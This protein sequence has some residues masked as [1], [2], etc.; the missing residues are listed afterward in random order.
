MNKKIKKMVSLF[1]SMAM[2]VTMIT[3][4]DMTVKASYDATK[5]LNVYFKY[6]G[7]D[8]AWTTVALN[9][10]SDTTVTTLDGAEPENLSVLAWGATAAFPEMSKNDKGWYEAKV[11]GE[12]LDGIDFVYPINGD[13]QADSQAKE[14]KDAA[15][16]L[17]LP[18]DA[19]SIY[20]VYDGTKLSAYSDEEC[21]KELD[22]S[23]VLH[24]VNTSNWDEVKVHYWGNISSDVTTQTALSADETTGWYDIKIFPSNDANSAIMFYKGDWENKLEL[25]ECFENG[26]EEYWVV[27]NGL[28]YSLCVKP[29]SISLP[30]TAELAK[31]K[32]YQLTATAPDNGFAG[33]AFT[34]SDTDVATVNAAGLVTGVKEGTATI[35]AQSLADN[36]LTATCEITVKQE[37]KVTEIKVS[38]E[39]LELKKGQ[40]TVLTADVLPED[41]NNKEV[42]WSSSDTDVVTVDA[43]SGLVTGVSA[44]TAIVTATA[45]DGSD[46]KGTCSVTVLNEETVKATSAE[47]AAADGTLVAGDTVELKTTVAPDNADYFNLSYKSSNE[48]VATVSEDGVVTAVGVGTATITVNTDNDADEF[49]AGTCIITVGDKYSLRSEFTGWDE[50]DEYSFRYTG[51]TSMQMKST[52]ELKKGYYSF[53]CAANGW[54]TKLGGG[55]NYDIYVNKD[56]IATVTINYTTTPD[57]DG[58]EIIFTGTNADDITTEIPEK[59]EV[60]TVVGGA[61]GDAWDWYGSDKLMQLNSDTGLYEYTWSGLTAGTKYIYQLAQDGETFGYK[62]QINDEGKDFTYTPSVQGS[63]HITYDKDTGEVS[64]EFWPSVTGVTL[65]QKTAE[66]LIGST[67]ELTATVT[68]KDAKNKNVSWSSDNE[69]VAVVEDGFVTAKAVGKANITVTTEDGQN[70]DICEVTVKPIA[71]TEVSL[72]NTNL[73][74]V[75]GKTF[76]LVATVTPSNATDKSVTWSSSDE[77]V[78]TVKDGVVTAVAVGKA[79]ITVT[80]KDGGKTAVCTVNVSETEIP[81]TGI[82]INKAATELTVGGNETLTYTVTPEDANNSDTVEWSSSD[83]NVATVKDGVVTAVSAGTAVIKVTVNGMFTQECTVTVK[84]AIISVLGIR[85]DKSEADLTEGETVTLNATVLPENATDKTY[86]WSTSNEN[87]ATVKD[88]VV[89]AVAAGTAIITVTTTDG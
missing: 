33:V 66:V 83:E 74:I 29:T 6:T 23:I 40:A 47:I 67:I 28:S 55:K 54:D 89:T 20:Y 22:A 52:L 37:V 81:I 25:K 2:I 27:E 31:G 51:Q 57:A 60:Y 26:V 85:L 11:T 4:P 43:E 69:D 59:K 79:T 42:T 82:T 41:A 87:V 24:F 48:K 45:M 75:K 15:N 18:A 58:A 3:V 71:V 86:T 76:G 46:V 63:L 72:N 84:D 21:K 7:N 36:S 38:K 10:W 73:G 5:G 9:T 49:T 17:K 53:Q 65:N 80:T 68:P 32:T 8:D 64:Q 14:A 16:F 50:K 62:Y 19:E 70:T 61:D 39:T 12:T 44:G 1:L 78:A 35:T 34:S 30:A 13:T 88:G 56:T 77:N